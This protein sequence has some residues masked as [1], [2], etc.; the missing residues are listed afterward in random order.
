MA[1]PTFGG[2]AMLLAGAALS[3]GGSVSAPTTAGTLNAVAGTTQAWD[4]TV[5]G[6]VLAWNAAASDKIGAPLTGWAGATAAAIAP[7][8]TGGTRLRSVSGGSYAGVG[9][10]VAPIEAVPRP[11]VNGAIAGIGGK[12]GSGNTDASTTNPSGLWPQLSQ[13]QCWITE[14]P[15]TL[16]AGQPWAIAMAYARPHARMRD[17]SL[18]T[19][20]GDA[21]LLGFGSMAAYSAVL[22]V[23]SDMPSTAS[24]AGA[25]VLKCLGTTLKSALY[26]SYWGTILLVNV[27]GAGLTA[28]VDGSSTAAATGIALPVT[29]PA[30]AATLSALGAASPSNGGQCYLQELSVIGPVASATAISPAQVTAALAALARYRTGKAPT[31]ILTHI[32]QS[33]AGILVASGAFPQARALIA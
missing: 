16:A 28:Y 26:P 27:P 20:W 12:P 19:I 5:P 9:A 11:R 23:T 8:I 25:G 21:T 10:S 18:N 32:G 24:G 2:K 22:T 14:A 31:V 1:L 33:N 13:D 15:V 30:T 29:W 17:G 4:P 6:N 7:G 3:V